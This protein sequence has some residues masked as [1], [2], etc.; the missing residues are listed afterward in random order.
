MARAHR[1]LVVLRSTHHRTASPSKLT[2]RTWRDGGDRQRRL[3]CNHEPYG[4]RTEE[5]IYAISS[6]CTASQPQ[7]QKFE[8]HKTNAQNYDK[9]GSYGF[10][11]HVVSEGTCPARSSTMPRFT[12]ENTATDSEHRTFQRFQRFCEHIRR[13]GRTKILYPPSPFNP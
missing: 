8:K 4:P 3:G 12:L 11:Y 13:G 6:P 2:N 7:D 9:S 1:I 5:Q 10:G